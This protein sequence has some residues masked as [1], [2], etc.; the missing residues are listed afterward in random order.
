MCLSV[1]IIDDSG[2]DRFLSETVIK[3]NYFARHIVSHS[4]VPEGLNYLQSLV[5]VPEKLPQ[6]IFLDINMPHMDGFD[7]LDHFLKFSEEVQKR[8]TIFMISGTNSIKEMERIKKYPVVRKFFNKPL[9]HD[10]LNDIHAC[11]GPCT[12]S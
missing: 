8:C 2:M 6:V 7:F 4:S 12:S 1:L 10:I 11:M 5:H 3:K 9:T